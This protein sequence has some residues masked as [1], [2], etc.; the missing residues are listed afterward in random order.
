MTGT[1]SWITRIDVGGFGDFQPDFLYVG[2]F[3][4][5][6]SQDIVECDSGIDFEPIPEQTGT[7]AMRV[8]LDR[9]RIEG[10]VAGFEVGFEFETSLVPPEPDPQFTINEIGF[11]GDDDDEIRIAITWVEPWPPEK[12]DS[13][14]VGGRVTPPEGP[15]IVFGI[16]IDDGTPSTFMDPEGEYSAVVDD[17]GR[18]IIDLAAPGIGAGGPIELIAWHSDAPGDPGS[19]LEIVTDTI[20]TGR[21]AAESLDPQLRLPFDLPAFWAGESEGTADPDDPGTEEPP[22]TP[23]DTPTETAQPAAE[24]EGGGFPWVV[25]FIPLLGGVVLAVIVWR[26]QARGPQGGLVVHVVDAEGNPLQGATVHVVGARVGTTGADGVAAFPDLVQGTHSVETSLEGFS[27]VDNP[28]VVVNDGRTTTLEVKLTPSV[29]EVITVTSESPLLDEKRIAS[30]ATVTGEEIDKIPSARDPFGDGAGRPDVLAVDGVEAGVAGLAGEGQPAGNCD[31]LRRAWEKAKKDCDDKEHQT[32]DLDKEHDEQKKHLKETQREL[33]GLPSEETRVELPDGTTLSELDLH[34]RRQ[35]AATAWDAYMANPSPETAQA[36]EDA[37][38]EQATP[39]WLEEQRRQHRENKER[40]EKEVDD[41]TKE[42]D[43]LGKELADARKAQKDACAKADEAKRKYDECL[44]QAAAAAAAAAA[45]KP[46]EPKE[47]EPAEAVPPEPEEK[48]PAEEAEVPAEQIAQPT[49]VGDRDC[50]PER[51]EKWEKDDGPL[52]FTVRSDN[53]R[54][55]ITIRVNP[56]RNKDRLVSLQQSPWVRVSE[57]GVAE[58]ISRASFDGLTPDA[59]RGAFSGKGGLA[60]TWEPYG[61]GYAPTVQITLNYEVTTLTAWCWRRYICVDGKWVPQ[62]DWEP[63]KP[64]R[65]TSR[66]GEA[67]RIAANTKKGYA[68][69]ES[70][71]LDEIVAFF[72]R[73]QAKLREL[74]QGQS[75]LEDYQQKCRTRRR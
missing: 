27:T 73:V 24:G 53:D 64:E 48:A 68:K 35:A 36:A 13:L 65:A 26:R 34:F 14:V 45:A 72:Q 66:Q 11:E 7:F 44:K 47:E 39:E 17:A 9:G 18:T 54:I 51:S 30:G 57:S 38:N 21:Q 69:T 43:R 5:R 37:W 23:A 61:S 1:C 75:A 41:T 46:P 8:D 62:F 29:E 4:E 60:A 10:E 32:E 67:T 63:G 70:Q 74:D 15:P 58:S 55:D 3:T 40:L 25:L 2:E 31:E 52:H 16:R 20:G 71:Y 6:T 19:R 42:R 49:P 28:S 50:A 12:V 22:T 56:S 59:I 33:D